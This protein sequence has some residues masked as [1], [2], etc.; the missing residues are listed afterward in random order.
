MSRGNRDNYRYDRDGEVNQDSRLAQDNRN[1][2][3]RDDRQTRRYENQNYPE[4]NK[5]QYDNQETRMESGN[6]RYSND[7]G[8]REVREEARDKRSDVK[9][10]R[11]PSSYE[12]QES[13]ER[14]YTRPEPTEIRSQA[15]D[16]MKSYYTLS[17]AV[18]DDE[19]LL[20]EGLEFENSANS[21]LGR[22]DI[23]DLNVTVSDMG[24]RK[25]Y[26][27]EKRGY[28]GKGQDS[29]VNAAAK[30]VGNLSIAEDGENRKQQYGRF[31]ICSQCLVDL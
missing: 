7:R 24:S 19:K 22:D 5:G 28:S 27:K 17:P 12:R 18:T 31:L 10:N 14:Q 6:R 13:N 20:N 8:T 16:K 25:T 21:A 4:R 29:S 9:E 26:A 15:Y 11:Y 1:T 30:D 3:Y 23:Q 2:N